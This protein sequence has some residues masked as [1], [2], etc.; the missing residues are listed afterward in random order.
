MFSVIIFLIERGGV[1]MATIYT[2]LIVKGLK[3]YADV[4]TILKARVKEQLIAL[5]L[6]ELVI[7]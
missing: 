2:T 1:D 6:E 5:E 4:P 7:E 3:T